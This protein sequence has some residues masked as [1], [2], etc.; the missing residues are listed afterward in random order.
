M[1]A[2]SSRLGTMG[3]KRIMVLATSS[4]V[5]PLSIRSFTA[6]CSALFGHAQSGGCSLFLAKMK[7]HLAQG[8]SGCSSKM[9]WMR[10]SFSP[11]I[12]AWDSFSASSASYTASSADRRES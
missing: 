2:T 4:F 12:F 5:K 11:W 8:V 9:V 10:R 6:F 7:K 3:E 1:L